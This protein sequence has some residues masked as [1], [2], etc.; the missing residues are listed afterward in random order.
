MLAARVIATKLKIFVLQDLDRSS[1]RLPPETSTP[2][3]EA[4]L[5]T[6]AAEQQTVQVEEVAPEPQHIIDWKVRVRFDASVVDIPHR[7]WCIL[8]F[9][10]FWHR[11]Y[12]M[13]IWIT[14]R[15]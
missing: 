10:A 6:K 2:E 14:A 15:P 8:G 7:G 1:L 11:E 13:A 3:I 4:S 9:C 5:L 12:N